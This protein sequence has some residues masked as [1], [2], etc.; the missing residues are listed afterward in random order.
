MI[1]GTV[2]E[3]MDGAD[4]GSIEEEAGEIIG[5]SLGRADGSGVGTD[6]GEKLG[7]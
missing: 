6:T 1:T 3:K 7:L 4:D 2:V 5:C